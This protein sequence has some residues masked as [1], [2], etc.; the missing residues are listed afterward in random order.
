MAM[1]LSML[2]CVGVGTLF[3]GGC[4]VLPNDPAVIARSERWFRRTDPA[5]FFAH[6]EKH[7]RVYFIGFYD[8]AE[9]ADSPAPGVRRNDPAYR[10]SRT[11]FVLPD[12]GSPER[13]RR[14]V[15]SARGFARRYN[16]L[17]LSYLRRHPTAK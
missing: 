2:L 5:A 11:W 9:G 6:E 10:V 16:P 8:P 1:R 13:H 12:N 4:G 7:G 3:L 15:A 17:V 14:F